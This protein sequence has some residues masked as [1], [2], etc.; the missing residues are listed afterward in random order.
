MTTANV[1]SGVANLISKKIIVTANNHGF[2]VGDQTYILLLAGDAANTDNGYY[3]VS[4]VQNGNSFNIVSQ[5]VIFQGSTARVYQKLS[6][7]VITGHPMSNGNAAY[8]AFTSGDQANTSNG[9]YYP[10]KTGAD[11]FTIN[12]AKPATG[13]SNVR[14]WYQTNNYSNI[15]FTTLKADNGLAPNDNVYIEFYASAT[16]LANGIYMV[17]SEY[18]SN[19]YNIYYDGNTYIQ[20]AFTTYG[21]IVTIPGNTNNTINIVAHSGLGIVSGSVMEGIAYVSPYK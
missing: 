6:K 8:I 17:K 19:T 4:Q 16:D 13:N 15:R 5:N 14:V 21:S 18:N 1:G 10:I 9:I 7:I 2:S 11:V 20:N 3:T 12:V